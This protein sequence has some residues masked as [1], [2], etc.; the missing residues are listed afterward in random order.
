MAGLGL[1][2]TAGPV[3]TIAVLVQPVHSVIWPFCSTISE[4]IRVP[5][6]KC[7]V[8]AGPVGQACGLLWSR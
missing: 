7:M 8:E 6:K 2:L 4:V 3:L 1:L 5:E